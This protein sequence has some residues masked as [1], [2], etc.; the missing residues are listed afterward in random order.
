M[1]AAKHGRARPLSMEQGRA[2]LPNAG[3]LNVAMPGERDLVMTRIFDAPRTLVFDAWTKPEMMRRWL[4]GP[5]GWSMPVCEIDLRVGGCYRLVWRN[6]AGNEFGLRGE[7]REVV[8][9][10]KLVATERFEPA[11]YPGGATVSTVLI[12]RN[13]KTT[14]ITTVRYDDPEA[15][16]RAVESNMSHGVAASYNRL[17]NVIRLKA[18]E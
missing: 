18:A 4:L 8:P 5:D 1:K 2:R 10:E 15:R 11:W 13:G 6:D 16:K 9:G 17:E 14:A 7:Y 12:E 3:N